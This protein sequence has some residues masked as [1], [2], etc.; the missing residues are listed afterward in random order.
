M[1]L[2]IQTVTQHN[3][4]GSMVKTSP[5]GLIRSFIGYSGMIFVKFENFLDGSLPFVQD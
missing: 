2:G 1:Y 4:K 3:T 5:S